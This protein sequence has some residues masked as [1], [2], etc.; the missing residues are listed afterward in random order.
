MAKRVTPV[1][2]KKNE[3]YE[4]TK[5]A[6]DKFQTYLQKN[7]K[8]FQ[9]LNSFGQKKDQKT[10]DIKKTMQ[11]NKIQMQLILKGN[12][13][14][15][16]KIGAQIYFDINGRS[17][18]D[19]FLRN[20]EVSI[21]GNE[22]QIAMFEQIVSITNEIINELQVEMGIT[23]ACVPIPAIF[24]KKLLGPGHSVINSIEK[25]TQVAIYYHRLFL[26]EECYPLDV[27]CKVL[28]KGGKDSILRA[29]EE[30]RKRVATFEIERL[31]FNPY[32]IKTVVNNMPSLKRKTGI[33][34][35]RISR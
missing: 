9:Q 15:F 20:I 28:I 26:S 29:Y 1:S 35:F 24:L 27:T 22:E 31:Y 17:S 14:L 3:F 33:A 25:S 18:V 23:E 30:I 5:R 13:I 8:F 34:E 6:I 11:L 32:E 16:E 21:I 10:Q 2:K 7:Q 4:V 19:Y 12:F